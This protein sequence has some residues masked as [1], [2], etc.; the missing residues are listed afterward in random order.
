MSSC[1]VHKF[2]GFAK[3]F[4]VVDGRQA[5]E[6]QIF[7]TGCLFLCLCECN[8]KCQDLK[9]IHQKGSFD[10]S[11]DI[12]E[13]FL[14]SGMRENHPESF[15]EHRFWTPYQQDSESVDLG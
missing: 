3:G 9:Q 4:G 10:S 2:S 14:I 12:E 13:C 11:G 8:L 1:F 5:S 6:Y 15:L 7:R